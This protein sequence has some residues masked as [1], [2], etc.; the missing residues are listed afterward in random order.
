MTAKFCQQTDAMGNGC[1]DSWWVGGNYGS[2]V[3]EN[4]DHHKKEVKMPDDADARGEDGAS[5]QQGHDYIKERAEW[6]AKKRRRMQIEILKDSL[7]WWLLDVTQPASV[8]STLSLPADI[9]MKTAE[10]RALEAIENGT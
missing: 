8:A 6:D 10:L 4:P 9:L 1:K 5:V 7:I 3:C 2:A